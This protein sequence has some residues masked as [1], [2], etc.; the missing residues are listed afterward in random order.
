MSRYCA[1]C[2][3]GGF[4]LVFDT[5]KLNHSLQTEPETFSYSAFSFGDVVYDD[6]ED[7]FEEE[8]GELTKA[9]T[10]FVHEMVSIE[11]I[12][13]SHAAGYIAKLDRDSLLNSLDK[14]LA[15]LRGAA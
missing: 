14:T 5:K 3:E 10:R 8:F 11:D 6:E 2:D 1:R 7:K 13:D 9:L 12:D 4:A 15:D